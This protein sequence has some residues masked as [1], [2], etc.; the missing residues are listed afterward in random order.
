MGRAAVSIHAAVRAPGYRCGA[1]MRC[2][3][4]HAN[5]MDQLGR[6]LGSNAAGS[7]MGVNQEAGANGAADQ[8][9]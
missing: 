3:R 8:C 6:S 5:R 9:R 4:S 2:E 1:L 7:H